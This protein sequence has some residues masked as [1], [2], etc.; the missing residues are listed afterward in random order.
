M[1]FLRARYNR[2]KWIG[3]TDN[4]ERWIDPLG[5]L[6]DVNDIRLKRKQDIFANMFNKDVFEAFKDM[7]YFYLSNKANLDKKRN[8]LFRTKEELLQTYQN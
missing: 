8:I 3:L 4:T 6:L 1:S 5:V 7:K 2:H